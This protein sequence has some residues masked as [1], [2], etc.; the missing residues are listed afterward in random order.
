VQYLS[1]LF[2]NPFPKVKSSNTSIKKIEKLITSLQSEN[3]YSYGETS[4]KI[5]KLMLPLL[6]LL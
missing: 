1:Q 6:I 4:M 5:L 2:K 3:S